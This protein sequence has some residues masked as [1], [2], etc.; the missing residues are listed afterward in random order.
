MPNLR[1]V[2]TVSAGLWVFLITGWSRTVPTEEAFRRELKSNERLI[3]YRREALPG[4]DR[5]IARARILN[6]D[7]KRIKEVSLTPKG[8]ETLDY[9]DLRKLEREAV[10]RKFG[11]G[12]AGFEAAMDRKLPEELLFTVQFVAGTDHDRAAREI[13]TLGARIERRYQNLA[14][15]HARPDI[16]K[17]IARLESVEAMVE[18]QPKRN[19]ALNM[20]R[21][22]EQAPLAQKHAAGAGTEMLAAIWELDACVH[23][24][25][26]DFRKVQWQPR[27]GEKCDVRGGQFPFHSTMVANAFAAFR[28]DGT[29]G[30]FQGRMFD[31]DDKN[32][33]AVDNMWTR[34]PDIVNASF[35]LSIFDGRMIDT[36]VHRRRT[37]H[38]FNGAGNQLENGDFT[39]CWAFNALCIGGYLN[40]GTIGSFGDD[41]PGGSSWK[42]QD[43]RETPQVVGP[44]S[45]D[46]LATQFFAGAEPFY[47]GGSG[48]SFATPAVAGLAALLIANYPFELK[49]QPEAVRAV[50]M[51]SAQA[52]PVVSE[53]K[54]IPDFNDNVDDRMGV[55]APNGTRAKRIMDEHTVRHGSFLPTLPGQPGLGLITFPAARLDRIRVVLTWDQCPDYSL[56]DRD[57][58][59]DLDMLIEAPSA[60]G[61]ALHSNISRRDNWEIVEFTTLR[62]GTIAVHISAPVF[63]PCPVAP[64][65]RRVNFGLAW[66]KTA[67]V[68]GSSS[69]P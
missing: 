55:G 33:V 14:S 20:A 68:V 34:Q 37:I 45:A 26:P 11:A 59:V 58:G 31:V 57:L 21:D 18:E 51:A 13:A 4:L 25:H 16:T 65:P 1:D 48:T 43:G 5:E 32:Q 64:D 50:L 40:Q 49:Q 62:G 66:T 63:R 61:S 38:V 36:E 6:E 9:P 54:S 39:I 30:L 22:L 3:S 35:T 28:S 27:I 53:G 2:I 17:K 44:F 67:A 10:R 24:V 42:D 19:L 41:Q 8:Q 29:A 15:V 47:R 23:R 46:K 7:T 56:L 60:P 69:T 12:G 52:H